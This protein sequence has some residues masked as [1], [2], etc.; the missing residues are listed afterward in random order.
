MKICPNCGSVLADNEPY[1][2]NCGFDPSF[3][4]GGS[5]R[6]YIHGEHIKSSKKSQDDD[7]LSAVVGLLFL[8]VLLFGAYV[9]LD[10]YNWDVVRLILSNLD[11]IV[12]I[13]ILAIICGVACNYFN[14]L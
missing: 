13:I 8:G 6:P 2:D 4:I 9:Y 10:M 5:S 3:D 11:S 14:N 1:C 7:P 12:Y